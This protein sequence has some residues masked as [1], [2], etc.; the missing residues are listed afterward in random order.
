VLWFPARNGGREGIKDVHLS[1]CLKLL[2][3]AG[4]S[5]GRDLTYITRHFINKEIDH[6]AKM[7]RSRHWHRSVPGIV[8]A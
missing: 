6:L 5:Q 3:D 7:I 4:V 2:G 8:L 1:C